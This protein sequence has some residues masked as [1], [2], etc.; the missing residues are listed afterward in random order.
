[1]RLLFSS[2][3]LILLLTIIT[4]SGKSEATAL[5]YNIGANEKACFYV[6]T[7]KPGKKIGFY[8]AVQQGGSFDIDYEVKG[9]REEIILNGQQEK[10]ADYVFTATDVGEYSFC[11]ANEM[12]TFA[13]KLVD[14]EILVEHEVRPEFKKDATGKEQPAT[15]TAM[16]DTLLSIS[17]SLNKIHRTQR[18][19][20]TRENRNSATVFST[21]DRL[22]WFFMLESLAIISIAV[23]QTFV[24]KNFF[25]VK[26]GGV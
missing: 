14:F 21:G 3:I 6:M 7:D 19:F 26:K 4:F 17:A 11:F 24:I 16:E 10:Q 5:T 1:M 12:S 18:Y 20:R 2:T 13:E 22:F 23:L 9:P 25:N 15:L 8:F